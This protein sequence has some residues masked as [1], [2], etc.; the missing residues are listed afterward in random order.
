MRTYFGRPSSNIRFSTSTGRG[1]AISAA[2][3]SR[4]LAEKTARPHHQHQQHHE[5]HEGERQVGQVIFVMWA[6]MMVAMML[7]SAAPVT[8]LIGPRQ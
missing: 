4:L 5:V 7:P 1:D 3:G 8:L 6:V 2:Q